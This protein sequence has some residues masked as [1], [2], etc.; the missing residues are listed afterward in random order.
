LD[1]FKLIHQ[2]VILVVQSTSKTQNYSEQ[3]K[4]DQ[5]IHIPTMSQSYLQ[6]GL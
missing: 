1:Y 6:I 4:Q 2:K 3:Q 5:L